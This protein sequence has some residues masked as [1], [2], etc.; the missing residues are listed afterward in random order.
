MMP[1]ARLQA[2]IA[3]PALLHPTGGSTRRK[4]TR[5]TKRPPG[6]G[7]RRASGRAAIGRGF[8]AASSMWWPSLILLLGI[9]LAGSVRLALLSHLLSTR[10]HARHLLVAHGLTG[11]LRGRGAER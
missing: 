9:S 11:C 1:G 5:R 6:T 4:P 8:R 2:V 3:R 7:S 10:Q